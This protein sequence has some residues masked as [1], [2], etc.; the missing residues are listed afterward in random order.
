[1]EIKHKHKWEEGKEENNK[2][3]YGSEIYR[4]AA[5][6]AD[7]MEREMDN[8]KSIEDIA[9]STSH[10]ADTSGITGFMYGAAV[11]ILSE[12]WEH[13]EE[14]RQWHNLDSQI[15]DEGERANK[16]GAVLNPAILNL[17]PKKQ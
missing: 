3:R 13:G 6:W 15:K 7:L 17:E 9:K 1:M 4:F 16:S 2:D 14:L 10:E 5:S 11:L 8:G 12:C